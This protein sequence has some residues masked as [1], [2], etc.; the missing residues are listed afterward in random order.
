MKFLDVFRREYETGV[1]NLHL[2]FKIHEGPW[3]YNRHYSPFT[4]GKIAVKIRFSFDNPSLLDKCPFIA[5]IGLNNDSNVQG[6][7]IGFAYGKIEET[8]SLATWAEKFNYA[9]LIEGLDREGVSSPDSKVTPLTNKPAENTSSNENMPTGNLERKFSKQLAQP[10]RDETAKKLREA[11]RLPKNH[12]SLQKIKKEYKPKYEPNTQKEIESVEKTIFG[13]IFKTYEFKQLVHGLDKRL[14]STRNS[15]IDRIKY[16]YQAELNKILAESPLTEEEMSM[17]LSEEA[18]VSMNL[19]D[20]QTLLKRL[21]GNFVTHVTRQGIREQGWFHDAGMGDFFDSF[22]KILK[23]KKLESFLASFM[24]D[25]NSIPYLVS[26]IRRAKEQT[27]LSGEALVDKMLEIAELSHDENMPADLSSV[28]VATND[29]ASYYYGAEKGYD[30]YFYYPAEFIAYNYFHHHKGKQNS[31]VERQQ[32]LSSYSENDW[33]DKHNDLAIWN[34]G[35]GVPINAGITCIPKDVKV[36]RIT[37]SQ[38]KIV[39]GKPIKKVEGHEYELAEDTITSEEFWE[40]YFNSNPEMRPNKLIYGN[41]Q[42]IPRYE[43]TKYY[44]PLFQRKVFRTEKDLPGYEEAD[45]KMLT[46]YK[47][48]LA[49]F[50]RKLEEEK[51]I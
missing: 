9:E 38:Y 30:F 6:K 32:G 15:K 34:E 29:I 24:T 31:T 17:Y 10:L 16:D 3:Y 46:Q 44:E 20:Y 50:I 19:E 23:S 5:K 33:T 27:R 40:N 45:M 35:R 18:M 51:I 42:T 48:Q 2:D 43:G 37:G 25:P 49:G 8:K 13:K 4:D 12:E 1:R 14:Q 21:S 47:I 28:H 41:F 7:Y 36:D 26:N 11:R 22:T 39:D